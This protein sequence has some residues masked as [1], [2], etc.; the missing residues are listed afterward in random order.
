MT[1]K[2]TGQGEL[3]D[4]KPRIGC[5]E[6]FFRVINTS[7]HGEDTGKNLRLQTSKKIALI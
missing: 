7:A 1:W 4:P 6:M 5:P 3:G 2:R